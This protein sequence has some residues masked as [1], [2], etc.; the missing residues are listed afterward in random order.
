DRFMEANLTEEISAVDIA[1]AAGVPVRT[2]YHAFR[3]CRGVSPMVWLR[4]LRLVRA[5]FDLLNGEPGSVNVTDVAH[6]YQMAHM[7]RFARSYY[8][9]FGEYPSRTM[10]HA[11]SG[12]SRDA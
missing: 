4:S 9:E 1:C 11:L 8:Q 10:R 2:L 3:K 6:R 5:R 12:Q 7:G